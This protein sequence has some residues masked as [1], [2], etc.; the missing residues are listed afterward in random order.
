MLV[1]KRGGMYYVG[2]ALL[3]R[4]QRES[5]IRWGMLGSTMEMRGTY[6]LLRMSQPCRREVGRTKRA[7]RMGWG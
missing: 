4:A 5:R 7:D 2:A 1:A 6:E 3:V